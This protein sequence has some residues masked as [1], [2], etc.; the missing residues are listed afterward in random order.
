MKKIT[1]IFTLFLYEPR[2]NSTLMS[3]MDR[4]IYSCGRHFQIKHTHTHILRRAAP[5][6]DLLRRL[7][8]SYGQRQS[9]L[10]IFDI[11][12]C[13]F[14]TSKGHYKIQLIGLLLPLNIHTMPIDNRYCTRIELSRPGFVP[15][16]LVPSV[17]VG[18]NE[19]T[20]WLYIPFYEY[21][22]V[23]RC[24]SNNI[25]HFCFILKIQGIV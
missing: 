5:Y 23:H 15:H 14:S 17:A 1:K 2:Q 11:V 6:K 24:V 25:N 12:V 13:E 22:S 16:L 19:V 21:R 8:P 4:V 3:S 7:E 20:I 18:S 10:P 9:N